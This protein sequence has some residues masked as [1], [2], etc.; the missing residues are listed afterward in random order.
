MRAVVMVSKRTRKVIRW[1]ESAADA[2]RFCGFKDTKAVSRMCRAKSLPED[3]W[4][5]RYEDEFDPYEDFTGRN[6]CPVLIHDTIDGGV[7]WFPTRK[8]LGE[9]VG[10]SVSSIAAAMSKK[11]RLG[12]RYRVADAGRRLR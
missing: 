4:Y 9:E 2:A 8:A 12:G 6:N 10:Y 3:S 1:F 11:C 7:R 5:L